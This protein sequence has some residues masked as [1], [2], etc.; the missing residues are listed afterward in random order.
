MERRS[1]TTGILPLLPRSKRPASNRAC[2]KWSDWQRTKGALHRPAW[3]PGSSSRNR[4]NTRK[5]PTVSVKLYRWRQSGDGTSSRTLRA[6]TFVQTSIIYSLKEHAAP[7]ECL[8]SSLPEGGLR[9]PRGDVYLFATWDVQHI[10][11][12]GIPVLRSLPPFFSN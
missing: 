9:H 12:T 6:G 1:F 10:P 4:M 3:A 8:Y 2:M 7:S 5:C 11:E